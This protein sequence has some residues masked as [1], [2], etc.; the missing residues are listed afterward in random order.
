M[1][2]AKED[3]EKI[4][5]KFDSEVSRALESPHVDFDEN[6]DDDSEDLDL[7]FKDADPEPEHSAT[8]DMQGPVARDS[9]KQDEIVDKNPMYSY[10]GKKREGVYDANKDRK[11][12]NETV[13]RSRSG[14]INGTETYETVDV[15]FSETDSAVEFT[16]NCGVRVTEE[17]L[18]KHM[19]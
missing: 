17:N 15:D 16:C 8:V 14:L 11:G 9:Y 6:N 3:Y 2:K 4:I 10:D 12:S 1:D 18:P 7:N 5:A 13:Y 19:A